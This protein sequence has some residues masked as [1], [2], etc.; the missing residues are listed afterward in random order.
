[1]SP[2]P[3]LS[4]PREADL[5]RAAAAIQEADALIIAAG[6]GIGVDSGLPDFRGPD[7][8]WRAYPAIGKLGLS[9]EEVAN[10]RWFDEDPTLAWAFYGH[11]L[12]LYRATKPH[13]GFAQLLAWAHSKPLGSFVFTSNVDGQFQQAGF[14]SD[15]I[16]ECHGS[17]H[18]FQC[19]RPCRDLVWDSVGET[20]D[21]N[22]TLFRAVPPLPQ[23]R[24]CGRL[25]RPNVLMFGD[26]S[27]V[28]A[29]WFSQRQALEHW[30]K[31]LKALNARLAIIELGAGTAIPSVRNFSE[32]ITAEFTASL[33]RL[34]PRE[35]QVPP[36]QFGFDLSAL[37]GLQ[38]LAALM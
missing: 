3:P 6:A 24:H 1:M 4:A 18:H 12:N 14:S 21:V 33:I 15:R 2:V 19:V 27:W 29:R 13:A 25:A 16:L 11:R 35:S 36:G 23:C 32:R 9:F 31:E 5:E 38:R 7:G 30:L 17:L 8:F 37:D 34:N 22:E 20:V 28:E 10:P 26:V